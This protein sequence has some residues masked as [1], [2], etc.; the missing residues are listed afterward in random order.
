MYV[1]RQHYI[2]TKYV[3]EDN[4][5]FMKWYSRVPMTSFFSYWYSRVLLV[6]KEFMHR[7]RY[8]RVRR[9]HSMSCPLSNIASLNIFD[10]AFHF[11]I[12][13][14]NRDATTFYFEFNSAFHLRG[15]VPGVISR[16]E[17]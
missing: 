2:I 16:L 8:C 3:A 13:R 4:R 17:F 5:E 12:S 9:I 15:K 7:Y 14:A 10:S 6:F 11:S 1:I